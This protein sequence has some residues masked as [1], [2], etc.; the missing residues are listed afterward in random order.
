MPRLSLSWWFRF[1]ASGVSVPGVSVPVASVPVASTSVASA[2]VVSL[3]VPSQ[4]RVLSF[5]LLLRPSCSATVLQSLLL[6]DG[7]GR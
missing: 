5:S 4:P 7:R 6:A 3:S 1:C 2:S